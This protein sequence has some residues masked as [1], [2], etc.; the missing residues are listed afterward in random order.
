MTN[1]IL[2]HQPNS[3]ECHA[4]ATYAP[5]GHAYDSLLFRASARKFH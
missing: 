1:V 2:C 4:Q 5:E 3:D